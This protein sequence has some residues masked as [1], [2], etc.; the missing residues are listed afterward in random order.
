MCMLSQIDVVLIVI[1]IMYL[2]FRVIIG[3]NVG[4]T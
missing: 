4:V 3:Y 2:L 1:I